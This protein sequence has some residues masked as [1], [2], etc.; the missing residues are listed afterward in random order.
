MT[1]KVLDERGRT[2]NEENPLITE[3]NGETGDVV[4][5]P[6]TLVNGSKRHYHRDTSLRVD[7]VFP[8]SARLLIPEESVPNY[9]PSKMI[10]IIN[11]SDVIPFNL[12]LTVGPDTPEQVV[13]DINLV[14]SSMKYPVP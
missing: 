10:R 3:H 1:L 14:I 5:L 6:L 7:S 9:T 12:R 8:V 11:P 4:T 13:R 2:V